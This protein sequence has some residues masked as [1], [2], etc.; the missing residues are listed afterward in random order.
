MPLSPSPLA[1]ALLYHATSVLS[2]L[3]YYTLLLAML[4]YSWLRMPYWLGALASH[5][6]NIA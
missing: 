4:V 1:R 2:S 5:L 6:S 3:V